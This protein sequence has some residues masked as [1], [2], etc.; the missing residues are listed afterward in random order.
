MTKQELLNI[1]YAERDRVEKQYTLPGW[2]LWAILAALATLG[3][4]AWGLIDGN[5]GVDWH[6]VIIEFYALFVFH[7]LFECIKAFIPKD[8]KIPVYIKSDVKTIVETIIM[9]VLQIG[10]MIVQLLI[11]PRTDHPWLFWIAFVGLCLLSLLY[12]SFVV[13]KEKGRTNFQSYIGALFV[14]PLYIPIAILLVM[15][16]CQVGYEPYSYRLAVLLFAMYYLLGSIPSETKKTLS[17]IDTLINKVLYDKDEVDEKT[18]LEELEVYIIGL[19]Y[20]KHL[21]ATKLKE[22]KPLVSMLVNYSDGLIQDLRQGNS[23]GVD[24]IIKEG[25][26][27]YKDT[28]KQYDK[29][30]WDVNSIYG[31]EKDKEKSLEHIIAVGKIA[32]QT[33]KFWR[34]MQT[35]LKSNPNNKIG[36]VIAVYQQTIGTAEMKQLIEQELVGKEKELG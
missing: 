27:I 28:K 3:W 36:N 34:I 11:I 33:M 24:A 16:L 1:L 31:E 8:V 10:L 17:Q 18:I 35:T 14:G 2:T 21:S 32:D 9:T 26:R 6:I 4:M 19:R 13:V 7:F 29:L 20:G 30:M 15:Y 12:G 5:M 25:N 23:V 22:L